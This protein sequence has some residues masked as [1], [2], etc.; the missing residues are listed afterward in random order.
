MGYRKH[1]SRPNL[2]GGGGGGSTFSAPAWS[3]TAYIF[4]SSFFCKHVFNFDLSAILEYTGTK[5]GMDFYIHVSMHKFS[6]ISSSQV[7][8][9]FHFSPVYSKIQLWMFLTKACP[10]SVFISDFMGTEI[11]GVVSSIIHRCINFIILIKVVL[12]DIY[13]SSTI[14]LDISIFTLVQSLLFIFLGSFPYNRSL[15]SHKN[16]DKVHFLSFCFF[17]FSLFFFLI[18]LSSDM[19][20]KCWEILM[21]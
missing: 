5:T 20:V 9:G 3:A 14:Y 16:T 10:I 17:F 13:I 15:P 1:N 4:F 19:H 7:S 6:I 2:S 21:V 8:W 18:P 12:L 11:R